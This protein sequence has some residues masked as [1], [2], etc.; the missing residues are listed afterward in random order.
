MFAASNTGMRRRHDDR[1]A[2][3][4]ILVIASITVTLILLVAGAFNLGAISQK[5]ADDTARND[6]RMLA[7]AEK[8]YYATQMAFTFFDSASN[9]A[10]LGRAGY[11]PNGRVSV[12][13]CRSGW[14]AAALSGSGRIITSSNLT[15]TFGDQTGS[16][17]TLPP[18]ATAATVTRVVAALNGS[19]TALPGCTDPNPVQGLTMSNIIAVDGT[20]ASSQTVTLV[21]NGTS[22]AAEPGWPVGAQ[23]LNNATVTN[24]RIWAGG[25]E[26]CSGLTGTITMTPTATSTTTKLQLNMTALGETGFADEQADRPIIQFDYGTAKNNTILFR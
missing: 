10:A 2:V 15:S 17:L 12:I 1:G 9:T 13:P 14:V 3:D 5:N 18:C 16:G 26:Y 24:V 6:L 4:P 20:T 11:Q 21:H 23:T 8:S 25:I 19:S 22:K 7:A